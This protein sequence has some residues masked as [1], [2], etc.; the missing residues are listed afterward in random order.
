MLSCLVDSNDLEE[1]NEFAEYNQYI[2]CKEYDRTIMNKLNSLRN[3][4]LITQ[5]IQQHS[6]PNGINLDIIHKVYL[7][8]FSAA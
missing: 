5:S 2:G 7:T 1:G 6:Y 8:T 3:L 4:N